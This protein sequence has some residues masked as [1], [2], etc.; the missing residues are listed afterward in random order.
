MSSSTGTKVTSTSANPKHENPGIV[1]SDSLAGESL[2]AGGAFA[3][4][5]DARGAMAQPS[6]ST[7][8]NNTETSGAT[9]LEA[10]P[11]AAARGGAQ[12]EGGSERKLGGGNGS[13]S[14]AGG[15]TTYTSFATGGSLGGTSGGS[16]STTGGGSD[17]NT[18]PNSGSTT[19]SSNTGSDSTKPKGENITEGGFSSEDPNASFTTDIGGQNDPGRAALGKMAAAPAAGGAG[20]R[21]DGVSGDGQYDALDEA[22]A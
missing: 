1:T 21:Q 17:E 2:N 13:G 6:A 16:S 7:T 18:A 19:S 4:D 11:S 9:T 5:S 14:A 8:T 15:S 3:A 22:S 20:P 12:E 10:A